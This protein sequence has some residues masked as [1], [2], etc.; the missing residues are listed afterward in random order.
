MAS[1][2]ASLCIAHLAFA[3]LASE[4]CKFPGVD[5]QHAASLFTISCELHVSLF[6]HVDL[7]LL[8]LRIL[9][10][11]E[12]NGR[13]SIVLLDRALTRKDGHAFDGEALNAVVLVKSQN[14]LLERVHR[15]H[16]QRHAVVEDDHLVS[17]RNI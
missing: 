7:A 14:K 12:R 3:L 4:T 8:T 13:Q 11:V 9:N 15:S 16:G 5:H 2:L 1:C 6:W 17:G 10:N